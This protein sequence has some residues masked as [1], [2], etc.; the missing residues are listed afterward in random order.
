MGDPGCLLPSQIKTALE[1]YSSAWDVFTPA[2]YP[3]KQEGDRATVRVRF[4]CSCGK[5]HDA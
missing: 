5:L 1:P 2:F 4:K 3:A